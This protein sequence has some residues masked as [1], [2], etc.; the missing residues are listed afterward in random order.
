[1]SSSLLDHP[2]LF[3]H[4]VEN[5]PMGIFIV[6]SGKRIRFWNHG[7]E[8]ITGH[9][10]YEV[11]GQIIDDVVQACDEHGNRLTGNER[12]VSTTLDEA[13]PQQ[14]SAFY[15]HKAGHRVAVK[16]RTRPILEYG[17]TVGG[18]SVLFE[19]ATVKQQSS[20]KPMHGCLDSITGIPTRRLT[21]AVIN[22]CILGMEESHTGFGLLRVRVLGLDDFRAKHGAQSVV[23]FLQATART[24]RR[25]LGDETFL[26]R[27]D[28]N[29]FLAIL[30]SAS[31]V[32]TANTAETLFNLLSH[33]EVL[34]WGD[35]FLVQSEIDSIVATPGSDLNSLLLRMQ[36][37]HSTS[38]AKVKVRSA[39][40]SGR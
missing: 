35:H 14:C 2:K 6:D 10:S 19:E 16:I 7:A 4:L 1:M 36:P 38:N 33:S 13:E 32:K 25:T 9:L 17:D 31:P 30:S 11:V 37:L 22:E 20:A 18:V 39:A 29:E 21:Q 28:E 3:R 40:A 5:L 26:G 8:N 12:P 15:L 24:L 27:W 23:P 34:W